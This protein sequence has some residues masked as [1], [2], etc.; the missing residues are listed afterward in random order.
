MLREAGR[1]TGHRA[2]Q[3]LG[4]GDEGD[5]APWKNSKHVA[6]RENTHTHTKPYHN[7]FS[8]N[9]VLL[10]KPSRQTSRQTTPSMLAEPP[11]SC[12]AKSTYYMSIYIDLPYSLLLGPVPLVWLLNVKYL[13]FLL[14]RLLN[15][16]SQGWILK[17]DQ[18]RRVKP[19]H[20][21]YRLCS[22]VT[23]HQ[24]QFSCRQ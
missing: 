13:P 23:L 14:S 10:N 5:G 11:K 17:Q 9:I 24:S 4:L 16:V 6:Q 12:C 8:I 3:T 19:K 7:N 20:Q 18:E 1:W 2:R 22:G 15:L 21:Y